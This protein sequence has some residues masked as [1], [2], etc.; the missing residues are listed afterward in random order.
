MRVEELVEMVHLVEVVVLVLA[1]QFILRQTLSQ[2]GLHS[3]LPLGEH[4][5]LT[6]QRIAA[7]VEV[8]EVMGVFVLSTTR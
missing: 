5:A 4:A 6:R 2:L 1:D 8:V 7:A 3:L